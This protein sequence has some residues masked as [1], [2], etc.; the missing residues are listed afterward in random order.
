MDVRVL[1][2]LGDEG[3]RVRILA[4]KPPVRNWLKIYESKLLCMIELRCLKLLTPTESEE[5]LDDN[6]D[7]TGAMLVF[8]TDTE[9]EILRAAGFV[10][11]KRERVN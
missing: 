11:Q 1:V 8:E 5:A 3:Y 2:V 4:P 6:F 9:V 10:E 7:H